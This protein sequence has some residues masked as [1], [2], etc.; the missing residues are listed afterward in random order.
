MPKESHM[1]F[2]KLSL[3]SSHVISNTTPQLQIQMPCSKTSRH[4]SGTHPAAGREI[5]GENSFCATIVFKVRTKTF[6]N[7]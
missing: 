4:G 7:V 5:R 3:K 1:V 2:T 6:R